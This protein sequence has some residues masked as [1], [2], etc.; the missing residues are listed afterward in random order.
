VSAPKTVV[1]GPPLRYCCLCGQWHVW[2]SAGCPN[3]GGESPA[4]LTPEQ[5]ERLGELIR[6][7]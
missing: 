1:Q 6:R 5:A 4:R 2:S 3:Q 7:A